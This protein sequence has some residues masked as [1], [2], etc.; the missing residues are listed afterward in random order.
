MEAIK[1]EINIP[2]NH[3]LKLDLN[4]PDSFPSG[5]AEIYFIIQSKKDMLKPSERILGTMHG[6][7]KIGDDFNDPLPDNFWIGGK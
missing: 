6:K 1:Q 3:H 7:V 5:K 4:I 2:E